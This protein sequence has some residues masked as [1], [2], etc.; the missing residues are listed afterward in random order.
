MIRRRRYGQRRRAPA[1][2]QAYGLDDRVRPKRRDRRAVG[3]IHDQPRRSAPRVPARQRGGEPD[4]DG[5]ITSGGHVGG[6]PLTGAQLGEITA[7]AFLV[8][9]GP[10]PRGLVWS[11][12]GGGV[13]RLLPGPDVLTAGPVRGH[14][15][16][17]SFGPRVVPVQVLVGDRT[18]RLQQ[19]GAEQPP[20]L[21]R[22]QPRRIRQQGRQ[23]VRAADP[24]AAQPAEMIKP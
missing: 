12:G 10:E 18:E 7:I 24:Q 23:Q 15:V 4:R 6:V 21:H 22:E 20:F 3:H 2:H 19:V 13:E 1:I 5:L 9:R 11:C 14:D 8:R 17:Q 16:T